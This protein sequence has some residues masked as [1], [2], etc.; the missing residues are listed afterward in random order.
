MPADATPAGPDEPW[1]EIR[2]NDDPTGTIDEIVI[3]AIHFHMEQMGRREVWIGIT[4][5]GEAMMH[6]DIC[7]DK[8]GTLS[9]LVRDEGIGVAVVRNGQPATSAHVDVYVAPNK[10][11][12]NAR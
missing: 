8:R 3:P 12:A 7:A 11:S 2:I 5:G 10:E 1:C 6:I 4:R 9:F